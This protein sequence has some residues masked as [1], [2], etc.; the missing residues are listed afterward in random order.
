MSFD[1]SPAHLGSGASLI[2]AS[3][4]TT[5]LTSLRLEPLFPLLE[6]DPLLEL[7]E[8]ESLRSERKDSN[9]N[10][11]RRGSNSNNGNKASNR[12]DVK[13]VVHSDAPIKEAPDPRWAG[14]LSKL[15]DLLA[16]QK[17]PA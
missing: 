4:C 9:S 14:E 13:K 6:F 1:S 15:K 11:S 16:N 10:T 8:F 7:P 3:L 12:K 2:G 5:F 17:T